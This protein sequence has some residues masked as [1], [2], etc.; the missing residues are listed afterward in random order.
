M[1]GAAAGRKAVSLVILC[2]SVRAGLSKLKKKRRKK[3][4]SP[5]QVPSSPFI[6]LPSWAT[7]WGEAVNLSSGY[8]TTPLIPLD[9]LKHF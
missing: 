2:P 3:Q 8:Q 1:F 4:S 9:Q 6:F 7:A 5:L